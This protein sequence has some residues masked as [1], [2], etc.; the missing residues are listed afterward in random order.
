MQQRASSIL[1]VHPLVCVVLVTVPATEQVLPR[2]KE[3]LS[4]HGMHNG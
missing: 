2:P 3:L 4:L 1:S